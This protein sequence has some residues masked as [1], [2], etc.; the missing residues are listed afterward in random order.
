[1]SFAMHT[2]ADPEP[3][4]DM[5]MTPLIDVMLVLIIMMI[6]TIPKSNHAINL[7]MPQISK[8][9]EE[10][11]VFRVDIA[12]DG[13]VMWNGALVATRAALE[14]EMVKLGKM[15]VPASLQVRAN[16]SVAYKTVAGVMALAQRSNVKNLGMVGIQ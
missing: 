1:M 11:Q 12:A 10:P 15:T 9:T 2:K 14:A 8:S 13:S 3:M 4:M 5:N 6:I 16:K 7:N